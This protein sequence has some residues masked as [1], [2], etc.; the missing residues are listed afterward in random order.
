MTASG[1]AGKRC[2]LCLAF[3][4][5]RDPD[6]PGAVF[7][8]ASHTP[9]ACSVWTLQRINVLEQLSAK[10]AIDAEH[11]KR[12]LDELARWIG[13]LTDILESGRAWL[14]ERRKRQDDLERLRGVLKT[15]EREHPLWASESAVAE[16]IGKAIE[17]SD[18]TARL[19]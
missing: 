18:T 13:T 17:I 7:K 9:E 14:V 1:S 19:R 3:L 6:R 8:F 15:G 4:E 5:I 2:P 12:N 10:G 11:T 16:A